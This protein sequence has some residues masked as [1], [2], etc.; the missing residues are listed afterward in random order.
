MPRIEKDVQS[1]RLSKNRPEG[2]DLDGPL[3][4]LKGRNFR[5]SVEARIDGNWAPARGRVM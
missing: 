4:G 5:V 1:L 3:R 2:L